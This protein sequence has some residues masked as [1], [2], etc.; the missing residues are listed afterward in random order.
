MRNSAQRER[1]RIN[2]RVDRKMKMGNLERKREREGG[3]RER[4]KGEARNNLKTER[5]ARK[6]RERGMAWQK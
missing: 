6:Q 5:R 4:T 1:V 3:K 2:G